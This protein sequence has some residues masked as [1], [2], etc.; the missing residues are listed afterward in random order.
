[1]QANWKVAPD[2]AY[3]ER[4]V[5]TKHG[6]PKTVRT[7]RVVMIEGS[8]YNQLIAINDHPLTPQA[9]AREL[10]KLQAEI[11]KRRTETPGERQR[12][13]SKYQKERHQDEQMMRQMTNAF[14]FQLAGEETLNGRKAWVLDARPKPNYQPPDAET[15][16][17]AGM[18]GRL[19]VDQQ[20]YQWLKVEA[21][22]FR[23]VSLF[24][25][26]ARVGPGTRFRLEQTQVAPG[27]WLPKHF[28]SDVN[29]TAL[30]FID[31]SSTDEETY[32]DY[33]PMSE[34]AQLLH[35]PAQ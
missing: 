22:V 26:L 14:L 10:K 11:Q 17:L 35:I 19:W 33:R 18:K 5:E 7:Y 32:R 3:I 30:G 1:M 20:S 13:T 21:E 25:F 28:E 8:Q 34:L 4:D 27:V 15:R 6:R 2:Y 29:A 24:G 23:P 9:Q 16:V 31:E 12:R